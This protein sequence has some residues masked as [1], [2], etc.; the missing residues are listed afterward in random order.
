MPTDEEINEL[1]NNCTWTQTDGGFKIKG[2]N[3]NEIFLPFTGFY[4]GSSS[5]SSDNTCFYWSGSYNDLPI[6]AEDHWAY[7]LTNYS[8]TPVAISSYIYC[9]MCIR[10]VCAK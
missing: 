6:H 3:G 2:K 1:V 10:P 8:S 4:N 7:Y 5:L 9:G